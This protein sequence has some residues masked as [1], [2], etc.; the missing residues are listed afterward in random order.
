MSKSIKENYIL[1][2]TNTVL[3]VIFPLITFPYASRILMADGIGL[4]NFY[5][6]IISYVSLFFALG[7]PMYAIR[8][9]AR[10]RDDKRKLSIST[11]EILIL[12]GILTLFGYVVVGIICISIAKVQKNIP[13]FLLLSM[14]IFLNTIGANW[15]YQGLEDYKY[16]TIRNLLVKS[17][18]VVLLFVLVHEKNDLF[19][20]A[21]IS[22]IGAVGNNLFNFFRLSKYVKFKT[23]SWKEIHPLRHIQPALKIWILNIAVSIYTQLDVIMLGFMTTPTFVGYFMGA[24]KFTSMLMMFSGSLST[25]LLPR[26]SNLVVNKQFG[27]MKLLSQRAVDIVIRLCLPIS[28]GAFCLAS[29]VVHL[30]CGPTYEP[31]VLTLKILS[32]IVFLTSFN[33]ILAQIL[34]AKLKENIVTMAT[35]IGAVLNLSLNL[36]LIPEW[37][38]NGA[39][40]SSVI[41]ELVVTIIIMIRG[42]RILQIKYFSNN[43]TMVFFASLIIAIL[44]YTLNLIVNNDIIKLLIIPF[45]Y[46]ILYSAILVCTK[47]SITLELY[48]VLKNK[49]NLKL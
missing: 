6:S 11:T 21:L 25:V 12:H 42:A 4:I 28:F 37:A 9:S 43:N 10:V 22:V 5:D 13:L 44:C 29:P 34:Y 31:S 17:V 33:A 48:K 49:I 30:L 23:F 26:F 1:N 16:I 2:L 40:I 3:G 46:V 8:E 15:F 36:F 20:Y 38:Q 24:Y 18:T 41:T 7:I 39:A 45:F 27:E 47:D 14:S 32:F 19:W 35:C